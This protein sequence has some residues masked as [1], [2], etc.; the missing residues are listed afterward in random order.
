ML[1]G[2]RSAWNGRATYCTANE[3]NVGFNGR[4]AAGVKNLARVDG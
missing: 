4:V 3:F 2:A 1:A